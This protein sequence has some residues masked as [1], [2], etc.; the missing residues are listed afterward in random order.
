MAIDP[1][2]YNSM[3]AE[4]RSKLAGLGAIGQRR[5]YF[6]IERNT[7]R[8]WWRACPHVWTGCG[9]EQCTK[10]WVMRWHQSDT[11]APPFGPGRVLGAVLNSQHEV[12]KYVPDQWYAALRAPHFLSWTSYASVAIPG[13]GWNGGTKLERSEYTVN[14]VAAQHYEPLPAH[15]VNAPPC[16]I[17]A[18]YSPGEPNP[19]GGAPCRITQDDIAWADAKNAN[20]FR[21]WID[22][23]GAWYASLLS[24]D[25]LDAALGRCVGA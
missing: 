10:C 3:Q 2:S 20:A 11:A 21:R 25:E 8:W 16:D 13:A 22:G 7:S 4:Y 15:L 14:G 1:R 24:A 5:K 19:W 6:D 9:C 23:D 17:D 18:I 12:T